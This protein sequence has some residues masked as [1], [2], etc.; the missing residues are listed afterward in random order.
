MTLFIYL[1]ETDMRTSHPSKVLFSLSLFRNISSDRG[2][3][4]SKQ[5]F[6]QKH[7]VK[8]FSRVKSFREHIMS[9]GKKEIETHELLYNMC[10]YEYLNQIVMVMSSLKILNEQINIQGDDNLNICYIFMWL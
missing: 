3:G 9:H 4:F 8:Y 2:F 1:R 6:S 10:A 5:F 7:N